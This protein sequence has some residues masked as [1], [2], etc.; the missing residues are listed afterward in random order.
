MSLTINYRVLGICGLAVG[1][2]LL[3]LLL[4]R[5]ITVHL[6]GGLAAVG[7]V[8]PRT[9]FSYAISTPTYCVGHNFTF[10]HVNREY[11]SAGRVLEGDLRL[12]TRPG[13]LKVQF[14]IADNDYD[15]AKTF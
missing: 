10:L 11:R 3:Y 9:T 12:L 1:S 14:P 15:C 4:A 6:S 8:Y 2:T 7:A 13:C 5:R